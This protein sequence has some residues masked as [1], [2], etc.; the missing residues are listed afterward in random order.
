MKSETKVSTRAKTT[1]SLPTILEESSE[2]LASNSSTNTE[3]NQIDN[4]NEKIAKKRGRPRK[5]DK[6]KNIEIAKCKTAC[7]A[8]PEKETTERT[9]SS[10][11][12]GHDAA[13][14]SRKLNRENCSEIESTDNRASEKTKTTRFTSKIRVRIRKKLKRARNK[15]ETSEYDGTDNTEF[16]KEKR[17]RRDLC[18][19]ENTKTDSCISKLEE[20]L[21]NDKSGL[22]QHNSSHEN[23]IMDVHL[24]PGNNGITKAAESSTETKESL[25]VIVNSW[26]NTGAPSCNNVNGLGHSEL[27]GFQ[28]RNNCD[29]GDL[30]NNES[31]NKFERLVVKEESADVKDNES[32]V[33]G[34]N[35]SSTVPVEIF[36]CD[37]IR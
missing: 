15:I 29:D 16:C 25:N 34:Q 1:C 37:V 8:S 21:S 10:S 27:N 5:E 35:F 18:E 17:P 13:R 30:E 23:K 11:S 32:D 26:D 12:N 31:E 19:E 20:E 2:V 14:I 22:K 24:C 6:F 28:T 4:G 33:A 36:G 3:R 7:L 9:E